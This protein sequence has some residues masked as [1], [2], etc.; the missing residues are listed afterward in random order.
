MWRCRL[1]PGLT[2][3]RKPSGEILDEQAIFDHGLG[4]LHATGKG[5]VNPPRL[6]TLRWQGASEEAPVYALV[7][8]G[9]TFDTGGMW[10]K[11][12][13]GMRTMKYDMCG[14]AVVFGM[15]ETVKRLNLPLTSWQ[16]W[17]WPKTCP[18]AQQ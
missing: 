15:M 4:C 18:A 12:G 11:E 8:K 17:R 5:S 7:G 14:A 2:S 13:E 10:L 16:S 9:I 6:V 1:K 3:T